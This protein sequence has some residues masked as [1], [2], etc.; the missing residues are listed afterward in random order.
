MIVM[1]MYGAVRD[2]YAR[3]VLGWPIDIMHFKLGSYKDEERARLDLLLDRGADIN[4]TVPKTESDSTGYTLLLYT[5]QSGRHDSREYADALHLL[6]RG[7]DPNRV[8]ADG[9]TLAKMLAQ[10][11]EHFTKGQGAPAEFAPLWEWAETH[12]IVGQTK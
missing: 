10:H 8:A 6:E 5:T 12:G 3:T 1:S 7:A 9:M 2:P 11:R 4:S